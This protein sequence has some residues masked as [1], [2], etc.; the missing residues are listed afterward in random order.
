MESPCE[1]T[2]NTICRCKEGYYKSV[3][4]SETYECRK[5]AQCRLDEKEKQKCKS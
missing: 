4:D 5:C 3:I 2:K 1:K